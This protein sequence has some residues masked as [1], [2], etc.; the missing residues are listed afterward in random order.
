[1]SRQRVYT[2]RAF[3]LTYIFLGALGSVMVVGLVM[4]ATTGLLPWYPFAAGFV[5]LV[6]ASLFVIFT[7]ARKVRAEKDQP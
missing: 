6:I 7:S 3:V 4:A 5:A 2:S 1:M